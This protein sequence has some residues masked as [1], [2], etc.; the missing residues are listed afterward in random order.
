MDGRTQYGAL[1]GL[2]ALTSASLLS[3]TWEPSARAVQPELLAEGSYEVLGMLDLARYA[4]FVRDPETEPRVGIFD[5]RLGEPCEFPDDAVPVSPP[6]VG[7]SLDD[8]PPFLWPSARFAANGERSLAFSNERCEL[9]DVGV[10]VSDTVYPLTLDADKRQVVLF[11]DSRGKLSVYDPWSEELTVI[12]TGV[13]RFVQAQRP[14]I[15]GAPVG[16]Q[17]LWLIENGVL[18]LRTLDGTKIVGRG[19]RVTELTQAAFA[20]LRVAYID[21]GNLYEAV[22]P[23]F[24]PAL[25]AQDACGAL[26]AGTTISFFSPCEAR[27][28]NRID[29]TTGQLEL[30]EPGVYAEWKQEGY[31]FERAL[32]AD[33]DILFVTPPNGTRTQ[34]TPTLVSDVQPLDNTRIVGR[35]AANNFGIWSAQL[36]FMPILRS[37]GRVVGFIDTRTNRLSWVAL[38]EIK[39]G[40]AT[41]SYLEQPSFRLE[42]IARRVAPSSVSVL[43]ILPVAEPVLVYVRDADVTQVEGQRPNY[44]GSL[45]AR[46]LSGDLESNISQ[47]VTSYALVSDPSVPGLLYTTNAPKD[48]GLWFAA[49]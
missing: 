24:R 34:V 19:T 29:L 9:R 10:N 16:P 25:L 47:D 37:A 28:L 23:E 14:Q 35:D 17:M 5:L 4:A 30:F 33:K 39:D 44:R 1:A 38:H 20:T 46:V 36:G 43:Q 8:E 42:T 40:N 2:L 21:A 32:K 22:A 15:N 6:I 41:L 7:P 13:G 26:Y 18:T 12:A 49:L 31:T 45:D 11:G 3:C 48:K 27:Q